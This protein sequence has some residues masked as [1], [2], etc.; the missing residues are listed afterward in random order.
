MKGTDPNLRGHFVGTDFCKVATDDSEVQSVEEK[1]E[2][3]IHGSLRLD[4]KQD[5]QSKESTHD[6]K[7]S[8]DAYS[9]AELVG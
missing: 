2:P 3:E 6:D 8:N 1:E 5:V 9:V 7:V 4:Q